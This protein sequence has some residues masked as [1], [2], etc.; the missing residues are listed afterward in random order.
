MSAL[1]RH[2]LLK[3]ENRTNNR[4]YLGNSARYEVVVVVVE[5]TD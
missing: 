1:L 2:P 3:G 4:P 5:R